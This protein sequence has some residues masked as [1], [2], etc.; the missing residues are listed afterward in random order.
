MA[1]FIFLGSKIT[2]DGECSH[3]IKRRL[4]LGRKVMTTLTATAK[5]LQSC[6]TLCN[7]IDSSPPGSAIPGILQARTLEWV[8]ISFSNA[9]KWKVKVKSLSRV[10]L[11][12]TPW[13]AAY[14]APPSM[15]FFRQEYWSGLPFPSPGDLPN[16]GIKPGSPTLQA[17][18]LQS[19][20]P[21]KT[22]WRRA[23]QPKNKI[24]I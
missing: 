15:G 14:Q 3:E 18:T 21:G 24:F 13:T 10:R 9:C 5:S 16:P 11:L 20:P 2:A 22:P 8:A 4:L 6:P 19:E 7:P 23:W 17:D 12:A 1:D